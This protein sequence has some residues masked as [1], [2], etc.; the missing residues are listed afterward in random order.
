MSSAET[1]T[2]S[3]KHNQ[4]QMVVVYNVFAG[5]ISDSL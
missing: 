2:Q 4:N 3:A 5:W 1:F